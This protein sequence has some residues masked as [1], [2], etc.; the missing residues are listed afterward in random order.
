MGMNLD[1]L[2]QTID[3]EKQ[4]HFD[5]LHSKELMNIGKNFTADEQVEVCKVV[6]SKVL[7][8]EYERRIVAVD[9]IL[10]QLSDKMSEYK[11]DMNLIDKEQFIADIRQIVRL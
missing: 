8:E 2:Q 6:S 1:D 11:L 3:A 4:S 10:G 7:L 5:K 9:T